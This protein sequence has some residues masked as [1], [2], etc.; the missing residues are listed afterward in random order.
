M[1]SC[2]VLDIQLPD[3]DGFELQ[4]QLARRDIQVPIIFLTGHGDIPMSVRAIKA[5]AIDF[6]TKPFNDEYL[7]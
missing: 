6:L 1:P 2:L 3:L 4:D 5:G 7:L